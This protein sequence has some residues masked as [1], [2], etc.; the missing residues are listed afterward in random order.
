MSSTTPVATEMRVAPKHA[1]GGLHRVHWAVVGA[2]LVLTIV[3]SWITAKNA[4]QRQRSEFEQEAEQAVGLVLERMEKYEGGLWAGVSVV[5]SFRSRGTEMQ[6]GDWANFARS[7]DLVGRYPGINGIGVILHVPAGELDAYNEKWQAQYPEIEGFS[8]KPQV[9]SRDHFPITF[10]EP[11]EANKKALGLDMAFETERHNGAMRTMRTGM[12]QV[13]GPIVLV[14]DAGKTPG[15][16]FFAPFYRDG[17]KTRTLED[18]EGMVYAPFV[19]KQLMA[20]TLG[21]QARSVALTIRD[22][23][24]VLY[25]EETATSQRGEPALSTTKAVQVYGR[26]WTFDIRSQATATGLASSQALTILVCGITIDVF[27]LCIFV[28][29]SR[30]RHRAEQLAQTRTKQLSD[31]VQ[32]LQSTNA[33]LEESNGDLEQFAFIASHDLQAPMR[34]VGNFALVLKEDLDG[35]INDE[36]KDVLDTM[37]RATA[38][39]KSLIASVLKF[40]TITK[41]EGDTQTDL[42]ELA[43]DIAW[44]MGPAL[45]AAGAKLTIGELPVVATS[46]DGMA[47]VLR[48]LLGNALKFRRKDT[49]AHI[50]IHAE[51]QHE[52]LYLHVIDNGIGIAP[53]Y[54]AKIFQVFQR[55]HREDEYEGSGIGLSVCKKVVTQLGGT[56]CVH[57]NREGGS[58]FSICLPQSCVISQTASPQSAPAMSQH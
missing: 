17:E 12:A 47:L 9:Q 24:V 13:T 4:D 51:Q 56:I 52:T 44:E 38:R 49:P 22:G 2:S 18:L 55:L 3:A 23:D 6:R 11:L 16:L 53:E 46:T 39:M 42:N 15:F 32:H 57:A 54:H 30:S 33:R 50:R 58:T 41:D 27:L 21:R 31:A 8:S 36:E 37:I 35:R 20:G 26:T 45:E 1:L 28:V 19:V 48:N 10:I 34:T 40:A 5:H 25:N 7:I 29:L 43:K 14:Q